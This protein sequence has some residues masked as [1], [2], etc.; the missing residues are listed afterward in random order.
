MAVNIILFK[1][2]KG[3]ISRCI[4]KI[5][6]S[7][8][9]HSAVLYDGQLYD[10]SE[11]RGKFGEAN[12]KKLANRKIEV[13]NLGASDIQV[14]AWLVKHAHKRYDYSGVLQWLLFWAFG[15]FIN[16][17]KLSSRK[18]VYCFEATAALISRVIKLKFPE[19]LHGDHLKR[20]LGL[21]V[22]RGKLK[23]FLKDA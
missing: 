21:P 1:K 9:T 7:D 5:T 2:D 23:E 4:A 22:Y 17:L 8:F 19:N 14:E 6:G 16:S 13:F 20:T 11:R 15:G 18:K 12:V 10:A 3:L